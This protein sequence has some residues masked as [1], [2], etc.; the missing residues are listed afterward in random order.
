MHDI[1][2]W[3]AESIRNLYSFVF[4]DEKRRGQYIPAITILVYSDIPPEPSDELINTLRVVSVL[5]SATH[6]RKFSF[7]LPVPDDW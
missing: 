5:A 4:V 2:I 7:Y 3:S 6:A 1:T